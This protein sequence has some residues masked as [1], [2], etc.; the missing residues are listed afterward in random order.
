MKKAII[1]MVMGLLL[2]GIIFAQEKPKDTPGANPESA[3]AKEEPAKL[4]P[5]VQAKIEELIERLGD[6]KIE[7]RDNAQKYLEEIGALTESFLLTKNAQNPDAEVSYR[8]KILLRKIEAKRQT[9]IAFIKKTTVEGDIVLDHS[10]WLMDW[11]GENP[12]LLVY[13]IS[14]KPPCWSPDGDK[15]AL[16]VEGQLCIEYVNSKRCLGITYPVNPESICWS[17]DGKNIVFVSD[18]D[19]NNE[20]YTVEIDNKKETRLTN[21]KVNDFSPRYS[22][23]GRKIVFYSYRNN[24]LNIYCMDSDGKNEIKLTDEGNNASPSWS[25]DGKKILFIANN[26][27]KPDAGEIYIMDVDGKNKKRLT[28]NNYDEKN[29]CWLPDG[30]R[31]A[32]TGNGKTYLMDI[33]NKEQTVWDINSP[34]SFNSNG[35]KIAFIKDNNVWVMDIDGKN[36]KKLTKDNGFSPSWQPRPK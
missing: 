15:I 13:T 27:I 14:S 32:F 8:I 6:E 21:N 4:D 12:V 9:K 11:D 33:A 26:T 17:P 30:K 24:Y 23:D 5:K 3:P 25:P 7:T 34:I 36:Q 20:I 18:R 22:P 29:L 19:G 2:G 28:E 16:S 1:I 10:L 31:I 35:T